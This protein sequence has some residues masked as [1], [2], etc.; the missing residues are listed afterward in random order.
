MLREGLN[1]LQVS[2][3][4]DEVAATYDAMVSL[5]PG[6]RRHLQLAA[7][8]LLSHVHTQKP[9]LLDL[10]CGSG[11]STAALLAAARRR[12]MDPTIVGV[13]ASGG[14]LE[15]AQRRGFD[16]TVSFRHG[17]AEQ[18]SDLDLPP[19]DGVLAC[20][21][22]RNVTDVDAT[23][24]AI[25]TQLRTR[26]TFVAQDYS[27]ADSESSRRRWT[28]VNQTIILPLASVIAR[29]RDLYEYLH[30]SVDDFMGV[31]ELA[32]RIIAAGF[33]TVESRSVGG[34]QHGILHLVRGTKPLG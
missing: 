21:L 2:A 34:W 14:M 3:G 7:E 22:L 23:L 10:G 9:V 29:N 24:R 6:Y 1:K 28:A 13:D 20:Y 18:L 11:L 4:F 30:R 12:G 33:A 19:A 25:Q 27:V 15:Q 31:Q 8:S 16:D 32:Q 17:R 5:N 26:A